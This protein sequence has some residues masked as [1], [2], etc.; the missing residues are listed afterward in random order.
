MDARRLSR[1][2]INIIQNAIQHTP[3][4]SEVSV[5]SHAVPGAGPRFVSVSIRDSGPGFAEADLPQVFAP[6]FSRRVG[7]FGLGLA[8]SQ[9]IIAEHRGSIVAA[10]HPEGGA[11][12]TVTLPLSPPESPTRICEGASWC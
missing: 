3:D 7:G 8:I 1:V 4:R 12:V 6:F 2:F 5:V 9:R 11:M 10:N